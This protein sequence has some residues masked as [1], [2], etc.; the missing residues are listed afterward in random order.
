MVLLHWTRSH[1]MVQNLPCWR[2]SLLSF[3]HWKIQNKRKPNLIPWFLFVFNAAPFFCPPAWWLV[4]CDYLLQKA[5]YNSA[6]L[7]SEFRV[8]NLDSDNVAPQWRS[9]T[10]SCS[11]EILCCNMLRAVF[12]VFHA[13]LEKFVHILIN[14]HPPHLQS[15]SLPD[16][17]RHLLNKVFQ[18]AVSYFGKKSLKGK[19]HCCSGWYP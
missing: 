1:H 8:A 3:L 13:K 7:T 19:K 16:W 14:F 18:N 9:T 15:S 2:A 6:Q 10:D 5:C 12:Q 4:L 17:F 11:V